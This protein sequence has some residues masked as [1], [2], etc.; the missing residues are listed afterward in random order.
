M[1]ALLVE[2]AAQ[3][4]ETIE[5]SGDEHH[6]LTRVRRHTVGEQIELKDRQ[7]R[8]FSAVIEAIDR[9][10]ATLRTVE[11]L[12][13]APNAWPVTLIIAV[14]KRNGLDPIV[15][16]ATEIGLARIV[17]IL[18]HRTVSNPGASRHD[19]W[20]RITRES[21]RQCGREKPL[22]VDEVQSLT[23]ALSAH[24]DSEVKLLLHPEHRSFSLD[25]ALAERTR[26][27]EISLVVGPEGGF[28][29]TEVDQATELGYRP[30]GL[31]RAIMRV[32]TAAI[33]AGTICVAKLGG[34]D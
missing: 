25:A 28:T 7:G 20:C 16:Q 19:R 12:P 24:R 30:V 2:T 5:V 34:F 17:P 9:T 15:R 26:V 27:S 21:I 11:R 33:V 32:E 6:Y 23:D 13:D 22:Q 29:P 10:V 31:G 8:R 4:G 3:P 18:S 1:T 14:P